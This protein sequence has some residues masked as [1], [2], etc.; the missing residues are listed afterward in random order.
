[1]DLAKFRKGCTVSPPGAIDL[2]WL[3]SQFPALSN[4]AFLS[5]G[6][7]KIVLSADHPID[8]PVVLKLINPTQ[9]LEIS[10][11][12]ILATTE[13]NSPRVPRVI[14]RGL[15]PT[16]IGT[17]VWFRE[18]RVPGESVRQLL[19]AGP[20]PAREVLKLG[21]HVIETLASAE[22]AKIVHRDVKP[23]N[24]IR[25]P[26]GNYWLLDFGLA[27]HL[28]LTSITAT[29]LVFGKMTVGYA[30]P[31]QSRNVK[32]D[33]DCRADLFATGVTLCEC[34]VGHNPFRTGAR[35]ELEILA[36]VDTV[37]LPALVLPIAEDRSF[38]DLVGAMTQ[39]RRDHRPRTVREALDWIVE[40]CRANGVS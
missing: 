10:N 12:E 16:P 4:L 17:C 30:P 19:R 5:Q 22:A 27:R 23:D 13:V 14:E 11:R 24:I 39:K 7:Q 38:T 37:P 25:D 40:I 36:R 33:I 31:E 3:A 28:S 9:D 34:A 21:L 32:G 8:G 1:M 15:L 18:E 26:T 29:G 35:D 20:L 6:G 2:A